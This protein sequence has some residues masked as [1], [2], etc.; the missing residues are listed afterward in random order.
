[1]LHSLMLLYWILCFLMLHQLMLHFVLLH[2]L[3]L[4]YLNVPLFDAALYS[5][6]IF[7]QAAKSNHSFA[8]QIF[9]KYN[10]I[11]LFQIITYSNLLI[12][13]IC[14]HTFYSS[15]FILSITIFNDGFL[16]VAFFNA[17]RFN[18]VF[19]CCTNNTPLLVVSQCFPFLT[20]LFSLEPNQIPDFLCLFFMLSIQK[21]HFLSST[22]QRQV[23]IFSTDRISL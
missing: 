4:H 3:I 8:W 2:Y 1:M 6:S 7:M 15:R 14:K 10:S 13:Q 17:A 23:F 5:L 18:I 19:Y 22:N 16:N 11:G 20:T 21:L 12:L 9:L